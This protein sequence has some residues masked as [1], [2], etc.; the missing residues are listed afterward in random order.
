MKDGKYTLDKKELDMDD[1]KAV[2][3]EEEAWHGSVGVSGTAA[4]AILATLRS[5]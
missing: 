5:K 4:V 3:P 1:V 2:N